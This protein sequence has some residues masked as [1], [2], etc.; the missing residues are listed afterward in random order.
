[1]PSKDK[2]LFQIDRIADIAV[3]KIIGVYSDRVD[4]VEVVIIVEG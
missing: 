4:V 1:M 3:A 2:K